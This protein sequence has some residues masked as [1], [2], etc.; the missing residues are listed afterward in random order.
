MRLRCPSDEARGGGPGRDQDDELIAHPAPEGTR[1][2]E[3]EVMRIRRYAAAD[4]A[5]L[6]QD[7]FSVVLVA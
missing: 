2:G 7:E 3:T 1:L 5:C 6:S 4:K